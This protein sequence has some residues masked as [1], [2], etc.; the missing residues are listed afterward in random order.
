MTPLNFSRLARQWDLMVLSLNILSSLGLYCLSFINLY[1]NSLPVISPVPS[2]L[3]LLSQSDI[4]LHS[5]EPLPFLALTVIRP[6]CPSW[7]LLYRRLKRRRRRFLHTATGQL[8]GAARPGLAHARPKKQKNNVA[9][10]LGMALQRN[11]TFTRY[12][13]I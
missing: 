4:P 7:D 9:T 5:L 2:A 8:W 11:E 10:E 1:C 3:A 6:S 13:R 12:I